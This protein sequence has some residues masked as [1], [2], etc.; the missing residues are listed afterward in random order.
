MRRALAILGWTL[1]LPVL[2]LML[3]QVVLAFYIK[4]GVTSS[5]PAAALQQ[6]RDLAAAHADT[7][8]GWDLAS[9]C[10]GLV[11]GL[12]GAL[13]GRLPGTRRASV[14]EP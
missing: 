8:R 13:S 5:D 11:L 1:A 9:V 10:L 2:L 4:A 14:D 6:A 3:V 12:A 7:L